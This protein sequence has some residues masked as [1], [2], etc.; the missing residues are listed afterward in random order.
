MTV[1]VSTEQRFSGNRLEAFPD[2]RGLPDRAMQALATE[3]NSS[4]TTF[5]LPPAGAAP[6]AAVR[7]VNR[8]HEMPFAGHALSH[9]V[10]LAG[11]L[12]DRQDKEP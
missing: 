8:R 12:E 9:S 1:D 2:P 4:A 3:L 5:V 7:T 11:H 10:P 6:A